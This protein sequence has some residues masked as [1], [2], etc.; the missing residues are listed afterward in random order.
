MIQN[1][2]VKLMI[3]VALAT[4]AVCDVMIPSAHAGQRWS[5]ATEYPADTVAGR[6]VESFAVAL[7]RETGGAVT[8]KTEFKAKHGASDLVSA[9]LDD[10][11]QVADVFTGSLAHL[12]PIFELS[13]LPFEVQSVDESRRLAC[14]AEPAY[15]NALSHAGLHLL[16]I[17]PWPPTGL[18]SRQPIATTADMTSLRIRTYDAAS[19]TALSGFGARAAARRY[20][21]SGRCCALVRSMVFCRPATGRSG[22]RCKRICPTSPRSTTRS[23]FRLSS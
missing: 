12:D 5:V 21:T 22:N 9:V 1:Q 6:G 11:L 16:F 7:S 4:V 2:L 3:D 8:G 19:A 23:Q 15:R 18:W 10:R 17:S 20:R 13:T 14:L